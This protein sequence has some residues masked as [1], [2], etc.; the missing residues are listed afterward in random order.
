MAVRKAGETFRVNVSCHPDLPISTMGAVCQ[1]SKGCALVAVP[2]RFC[3]RR[4]EFSMN[5]PFI[6]CCPVLSHPCRW[7]AARGRRRTAAF[8]IAA[9][10]ASSRAG[11]SFITREAAQQARYGCV[12][13]SI[14]LKRAAFPFSFRI[15]LW[16]IGLCP[17]LARRSYPL[18]RQKMCWAARGGS[19][20]RP[21]DAIAS[22]IRPKDEPSLWDECRS[23]TFS[24]SADALRI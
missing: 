22:T 19:R 23:L 2:S 15:G 24:N 5:R 3:V 21:R 6:D 14:R 11:G 1:G 9:P 16:P 20:W 18:R 10:D 17:L 12:A 8:A 13:F 4:P 7:A